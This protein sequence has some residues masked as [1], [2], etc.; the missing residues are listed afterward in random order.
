MTKQHFALIAKELNFSFNNAPNSAPIIRD[1]AVSMADQFEAVN[2]RFNRS[3]FL[4]E[5]LK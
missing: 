2:P 3:K 4:A 1:L 5:A